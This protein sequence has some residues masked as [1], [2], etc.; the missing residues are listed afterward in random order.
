MCFS[1]ARVIYTGAVEEKKKAGDLR[2]NKGNTLIEDGLCPN[3]RKKN[4]N[5]RGIKV[6]VLDIQGV[7]GGTWAQV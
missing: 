6:I 4:K 3:C 2:L 5:I 7:G 1:Q